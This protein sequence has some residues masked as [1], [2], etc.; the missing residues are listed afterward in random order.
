MSFN[1]NQ[2]PVYAVTPKTD[3][4]ILNA[5]SAGVLTGG[6]NTVICF[7]ASTAGSR[8][9]SMIASTNDTAAVNLFC[10]I[11][12]GGLG[13]TYMPFAQVNVPLSSGNLA[14]T[15]MVDCLNASVSVGLPIDNVGKRYVELAPNDR[16]AVSTVANM[17]AAKACMVVCMGAHY[18]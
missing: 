14:S 7:T 10:F 3:Y 5:A 18:Q 13:T 4:G 16:I 2:I 17:T 12:K 8:V 6:T 9:Y 15:L 11:D 1:T